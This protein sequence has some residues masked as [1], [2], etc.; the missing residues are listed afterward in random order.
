MHLI[1]N[2]LRNSKIAS[3]IKVGKV[4]LELL[5]Q[6]QHFD[7]K[8]KKERVNAPPKNV[9]LEQKKLNMKYA[10]IVP[11]QKSAKTSTSI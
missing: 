9:V 11:H 5:I 4:V 3:K 1:V 2:C 8:L 6:N 10:I 7:L